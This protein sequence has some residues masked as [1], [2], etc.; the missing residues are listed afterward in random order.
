MESV[1]A[2]TS[3]QS[4]HITSSEGVDA[5]N[6]AR[7]RF[8]YLIAQNNALLA[9]TQF[10][11][12]KSGALLA[13]VGVLTFRGP[14]SPNDFGADFI[15]TAVVGA[16]I[17]CVLCCLWAI[18]PRFPSEATRRAMLVR[19]HY[20]WP[21][22]STPEFTGLDYEDFLRC[23]E[24]SA[25]IGSLAESN[26]AISRILLRKFRAMRSAFWLAMASVVMIALRE[27]V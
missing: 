14:V 16:N 27:L 15:G 12:A 1:A 4:T 20:S 18:I 22:L 7:C 10:S 5:N 25:L 13:L 23:S 26:V 8:H 6:T 11:D 21:A 2:V 17:L 9:Q 19:D 3:T 24:L